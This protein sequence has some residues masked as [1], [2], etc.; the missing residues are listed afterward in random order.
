MLQPVGQGGRSNW[1]LRQPPTVGATVIEDSAQGVHRS[2]RT[3]RVISTDRKSGMVK[4]LWQQQ[5]S[6]EKAKVTNESSDILV[7]FPSGIGGV[8]RCARPPAAR[9][10]KKYSLDSLVELGNKASSN[11]GARTCR[12][13][14]VSLTSTPRGKRPVTARRRQTKPHAPRDCSEQEHKRRPTSARL[15]KSV[16]DPRLPYALTLSTGGALNFGL[17]Q[18]DLPSGQ[19]SAEEGI[20]KDE[21][22]TAPMC[23]GRSATEAVSQLNLERLSERKTRSK[24]PATRASV[25]NDEILQWVQSVATQSTAQSAAQKPR[26]YDPSTDT[27]RYDMPSNDMS[28]PSN[29][30]PHTF[31]VMRPADV[32]RSPRARGRASKH[33][34]GWV[35]NKRCEQR[36]NAN[37][38]T[39]HYAWSRIELS[40]LRGDAVEKAIRRFQAELNRAYAAFKVTN[41]PQSTLTSKK[42][43]LEVRS[44]LARMKQ[45]RD[46]QVRARVNV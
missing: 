1:S 6:D 40:H 39:N 15:V 17:R 14:V 19:E 21:G 31:R 33:V 28:C 9:S 8:W 7:W 27:P 23:R 29:D 24:E 12:P 38:Q 26:Q 11:S 2:R 4:V 10:T 43:V 41:D 25:R 32:K 16:D 20:E 34:S 36:L 13:P 45:I 5:T 30:L 42:T 22:Q 35:H 44:R 37:N 46:H 3:G 18:Y